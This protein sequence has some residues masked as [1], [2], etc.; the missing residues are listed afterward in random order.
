MIIFQLIQKPQKRGAEIFAAQLSEKLQVLG[1]QVVLITIFEGSSE[2]PFTGEIINLNRPIHKR[3]YDYEGWKQLANLVSKYNPDIIQCNAGDTLKWAIFSKLLFNWKSIVIAR[4]ASVVSRY[5]NSIFA[6]KLNQFLYS[7]A[8]YI[9]SVSDN[10]KN[11]LIQLYPFT[12]AKIEV[13]PIG[14][15][16]QDIGKIDFNSVNDNFKNIV[17]VGGFTFEK[18]HIGLLNIWEQFS[19]NRT[20]VCLHLIGDGPL[21]KTI[22]DEAQKRQLHN[23]QFYGWLNNPLD[24][25]SKADMLILP[26]IIEGLPA[27]ILEAM[28]VKTPVVAYN[29][30][31]ISE[32]LQH[33]IT[34]FLISDFDESNFVNSMSEILESNIDNIKLNANNLVIDNYLNTKIALRFQNSYLKLIADSL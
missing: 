5:V 12:D 28:Y 27:V 18:N 24:Y 2:L 6:K 9:I 14:I 10:S 33:K 16:N 7:K 31:G 29:V 20:N 25:I 8:D 13:I 3:L 30:G 22:I 34:G 26:S 15:E 1:H 21:Q 17:H 19:K 4:N 11:D 32:V 23:I